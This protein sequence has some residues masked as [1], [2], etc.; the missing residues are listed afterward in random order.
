MA[1]WEPDAVGR[2]R[3]AAMALYRDPG[4]DK[5]TVAEIAARAGLTPR[6]FFRYFPDKREVLFFGAERLEALLAE[7]ITAAPEQTPA[8]EA[9]ASA[10]G[11]VARVSDED[12]LHADFVRQRHAIIQAYAELRER[13]LGKHASLASAMAAA[14]RR[15]GIAETDAALAA[16]VGLA[17]F[18][19]GF[20][21]WIDDPKRRN[22][23]EHVGEAVRALGPLVF[24]LG[25][26]NGKAPSLEQ[27]RK[28]ST[29][30]R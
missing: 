21:R 25:A 22:M 10:L 23:G 14:L 19:V 17:A 11:V 3:E 15:R 16:E 4:Y 6:T 27:P 8:L 28:K 29:R 30:R 18:K 9:V 12:P 20:E 7:A 5:V 24:E 13:E 2:L 26:S 1:R